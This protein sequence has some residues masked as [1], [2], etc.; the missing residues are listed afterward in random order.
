LPSPAS[1]FSKKVRQE[2][3]TLLGSLRQ[4]SYMA[5]AEGRRRKERQPIPRSP[6]SNLDGEP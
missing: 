2:T 5:S 1:S 3:C 6:P 4:A